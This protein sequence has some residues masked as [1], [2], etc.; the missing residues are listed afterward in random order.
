MTAPGPTI[1][2]ILQARMS[3]TRLPG[4]VL[5]PL[6][7]R[8]MMGRQIDRLRHSKRI[9][10]LVVATSDTK[11]DNEIAAFCAAEGIDCFR[12]PL[13]DVLARY[14]GAAQAFGPADHIT[15]LTADCPLTDWC[16]VDAVI[17]LHL[18]TGADYTSNSVIRTFPNGLDAEIMTSAALDV[19]YRE[20]RAPA[21]REHVTPFINRRPERFHI[22]HLTRE[23]NLCRL[24]WT[25]DTP[26][27]FKFATAVY[28]ALLA[29]TPDFDQND[30]LGLVQSRPDIEAINGV[31]A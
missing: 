24:R 30:I 22:E 29:T 6:L 10:K 14:H 2:A 12:G 21:E 1:L 3:S 27:D 5:L 11:D 7:G 26:M 20:A 19:A 9:D 28:D 13:Y 25:V 17:D 23:P 15:R 16:V 31:A 18:R 8:P 4:K